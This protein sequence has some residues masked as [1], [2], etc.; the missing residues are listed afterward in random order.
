MST[1]GT[2]TIVV[3]VDGS[4]HSLAALGWAVE[5]VGLDGRLHVVSAHHPLDDRDDLRRRWL[6]QFEG[7]GLSIDFHVIDRSPAEALVEFADGGHA[8]LIAVGTHGGP[9]GLP[10]SVGSV[11]HKVLRL[12][13]CPVAILQSGW[14]SPDAA[15]P[16]VVGVGSG[17]ATQAAVSW[18]GAYATASG[19]PIRLV[20][21][22][23]FHP[24]F[25]LDD[26]VEVMASYIDPRQ[27]ELWAQEE[28]ELVAKPLRAG[29]LT[30]EVAVPSGDT[31]RRLVEAGADAAML[32]MGK[33][34]DGRITGFFLGRSLHHAL[35]HAPCPVVVIPQTD[36]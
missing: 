17:P 21:S 3:G 10:K 33:H 20:R 25:G 24:M 30:V 12:A 4:E 6:G 28:V 22:V 13:P 34:L 19:R 26:A 32:V 27:L 2:R 7:S 31:G 1:D 16:V 29:G 8:D 35:T 23:D 14:S 15:A 11:A 5:I 9:A 18:A 36:R